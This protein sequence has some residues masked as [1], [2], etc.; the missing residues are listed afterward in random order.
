MAAHGEPAWL[1]EGRQVLHYCLRLFGRSQTGPQRIESCYEFVGG[2]T[3]VLEVV[4]EKQA[5]LAIPQILVD[6]LLAILGAFSPLVRLSFFAKEQA[7]LFE[8]FFCFVK[9]AVQA[10]GCVMM[11]VGA[12]RSEAERNV[13]AGLTHAAVA[14]VKVPAQSERFQRITFRTGLSVLAKLQPK[15][16]TDRVR[17]WL[18]EFDQM[19][20]GGVRMSQ[21]INDHAMVVACLVL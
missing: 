4:V 21:I 10:N 5:A 18:L 9:K 12:K 1:L 20:A 7:H 11:R 8:I 15:R 6:S 13:E 19:I 17:V 16:E 3:L 2:A 14:F